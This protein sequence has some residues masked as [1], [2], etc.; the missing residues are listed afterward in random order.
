MQA[1]RNQRKIIEKSS[2]VRREIHRIKKD[3]SKGVH[4]GTREKLGKWPRRG[5]SKKKKEGTRRGE[6]RRDTDGSKKG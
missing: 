1:N 3:T 5:K 4:E 2:K 6:K